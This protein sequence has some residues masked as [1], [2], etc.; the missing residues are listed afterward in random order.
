V[1]GVECEFLK[2]KQRRSDSA[3]IRLLVDLRT[4]LIRRVEMYLDDVTTGRYTERWLEFSD[5][6]ARGGIQ[7]PGVIREYT[8]GDLTAF[9]R[10][11]SVEFN[12]AL[13]ENVFKPE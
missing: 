7:F 6:A 13:S 3:W 8:D 9:I 4:L 2:I 5:Y 10:V 1:D 11:E 12:G